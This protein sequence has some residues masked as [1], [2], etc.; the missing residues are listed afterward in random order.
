MILKFLQ[1]EKLSLYIIIGGFF[2]SLF[3]VVV[4]LWKDFNFSLHYPIRAEKF[5][6]LGDFIGGI[7]GTFWALAG[8]ILFYI[9]LTEQR[10]DFKTNQQVLNLQVKALQN[11]IKEFELQRRELENSRKVYEEQTRTQR[12]QQFESNFYSLLNV[13]LQIKNNL[14]SIDEKND[15]FGSIYKDIMVDYCTDLDV[16]Q[17]QGQMIKRYMD[18]FYEN[19]S[20]LSHYFKC[21]YRILKV[22]EMSSFTEKDKTFYS[23]I[24]RSQL[25]EPEQLIL[26]YNSHSVYGVKS[27]PL[28]LK[29]NL[30][31]H[32]SI[33]NKPE[34][35]YFQTIQ[36]GYEILHFT[37]FLSEF[38]AK[39][40]NESYDIEFDALEFSQK[41]DAFNCIVSMTF[42]EGFD[43]KVV[44]K[45]N[46]NENGIAL[47]DDQFEKFLNYFLCEKIILQAY[48][49]PDKIKMGNYRTETEHNKIFGMSIHS[50]LNL[51]ISHDKY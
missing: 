42:T 16:F 49:I 22:I 6:Q 5:G 14:N 51:Q 31:K 26:Y 45:K 18:V 33:F 46:I 37:N 30:L 20:S 13:Y 10:K 50:D 8:V 43:F 7:V 21:F 4:F 48:R 23:K 2:L 1:R 32:L 36:K 29:Y 3:A 17:H 41:S 27:R 35:A 28:I 24:L 9:A 15:Y 38:L 19:K 39:T 25:T 12:L 11:Q 34:F 40:I 44:C 47:S